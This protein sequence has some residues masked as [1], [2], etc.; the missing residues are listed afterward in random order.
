MPNTS[1]LSFRILGTEKPIDFE[2]APEDVPAILEAIG[3]GKKLDLIKA[4]GDRTTINM[5]YVT[6]IEINDATNRQAPG[7]ALQIR[8]Y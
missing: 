7:Q 2:I 4:R 8:L 1:R 6:S 5:M 3:G